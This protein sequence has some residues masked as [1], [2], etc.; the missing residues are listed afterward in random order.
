MAAALNWIIKDG[1][2]QIS[3]LPSVIFRDVTFDVESRRV[4][5]PEIT[6]LVVEDGEFA[7]FEAE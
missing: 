3:G 7:I 4:A 2:G 1:L 5:G 6:T